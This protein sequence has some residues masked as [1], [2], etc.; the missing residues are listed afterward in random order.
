LA[1][2]AAKF[3][4]SSVNRSSH[5]SLTVSPSIGA[6]LGLLASACSPRPGSAR[7]EGTARTNRPAGI[8]AAVPVPPL[9]AAP[10]TPTADRRDN[11]QL[12]R[13]PARQR[14]ALERPRIVP[15]NS[16]SAGTR[17]APARTKA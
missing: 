16:G 8:R 5:S 9:S 3:C 13:T 4:S 1:R 6:A 15:R 12:R 10:A 17:Q 2:D 11:R 14:A 7:H